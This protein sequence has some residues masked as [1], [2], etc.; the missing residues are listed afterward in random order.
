[1][2][3][4][5]IQQVR[6]VD[7]TDPVAVGR[8]YDYADAFEVDLP[9]P[10]FD[11]PQAWVLAGLDDTPAVAVWIVSLLGIED[12][13]STSPDKVDGWRIVESNAEVVHLERSVPLMH[14]TVVGRRVG[15]SGRMLT[16]ILDYERP[17]FARLVWAVVGIGH[18]RM[19]RRAIVS[20]ISNARG[21]GDEDS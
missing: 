12:A 11:A 9:E 21:S 13:P 6:K 1:M 17:A 7:V 15:T 16:S 8:R 4:R 3:N 5:L 2:K 18:R 19:A 10:D 14:V 20:K